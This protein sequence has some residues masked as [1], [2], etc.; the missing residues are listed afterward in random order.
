MRSS[1]NGEEWGI[2]GGTFNPVHRGHITL[3][4]EI[5]AAK[6]LDGVLMVPSY[7][8]PPK[9]NP[10]TATLQDRLA[11]LK[12]ACAN[13]PELVTS[14]IES[15]SDTPGYTL[16]T[17]R[18][19]KKRYP[20]TRFRFIIGADL[21]AEFPSWYEAT[22]ILAETEILVGSRPGAEIRLPDGFDPGRFEIVETSLLDISSSDI[23]AKIRNG[24]RRRELSDLV[25]DQVAEYIMERG[26]YR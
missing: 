6:A 1:N 12:L 18:A 2:L 19:I 17:L 3:A 15:E 11:M 4:A 14:S 20:S 23:R 8:P 10:D 21:L 22:E 5:A 25:G 16:L 24:A 13:H 9:I 26:L 7:V